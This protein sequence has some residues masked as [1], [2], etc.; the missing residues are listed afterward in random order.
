ML[1]RGEQLSLLFDDADDW[2]SS[3]E[4]S[5][6]H[7]EWSHSRREAFERCPL[8]YYNR[9]YGASSRAAKDEPNK[10]VLRF[11][12]SLKSRYERAGN[13]LHFIIKNYFDKAQRGDS[14]SLD[15]LRSW[16]RAVFGRDLEHSR[17]YPQTN[18]SNTETYPPVLLMEFYYG[19]PD[20]EKVCSETEERLLA[21]LSNFYSNPAFAPFRAGGGQSDAMVEK[22]VKLNGQ[23]FTL[24]G[25]V[26]LAYRSQIDG[27]IKV[28]DWKMGVSN[29]GDDSLQL[30]FYAM[31]AVDKYGCSPDNVDVYRVH[32]GDGHV[33]PFTIDEKELRRA[34]A[35][36][37][38]D[39]ERM[40]AMDAYGRGAMRAAF[41]PCAQ[42]RVCALCVFQRFCPKE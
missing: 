28:V 2:F 37:V 30:A 20:A 29:S 3:E 16:A 8:A 39:V 36:I 24:T 25:Q 22:M 4:S 1:G 18:G 12:K 15:W 19:F 10:E 26:D 9:Y 7:I 34:K 32:L 13:I 5:R 21:A 40:R 33:A 42:P 11:M 23:N 35:R 27:R 31:I 6:I 41:T 38:Q 14:S 17:R